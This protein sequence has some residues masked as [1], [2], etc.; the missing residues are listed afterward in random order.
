VGALLYHWLFFDLSL[1]LSL[2]LS[3]GGY[4]RL[5]WSGSYLCLRGMSG[6]F[7]HNGELHD[8]YSLRDF[9]RVIKQRRM[10]YLEHVARIGE[11]RGAI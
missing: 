11:R 6:E 10:R 3:E 9:I 2:S 4:S 7:F 8:M 5:G 1:S